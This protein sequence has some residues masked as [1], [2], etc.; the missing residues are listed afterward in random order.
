MFVKA[1][2]P[3]LQ[4][5]IQRLFTRVQAG[6]VALSDARSLARQ[7]VQAIGDNATDMVIQTARTQD[8]GHGRVELRE[9]QVLPIPSWTPWLQWPGAA[10]VFRLHRQTRSKKS[11]KLRTE[12]VFGITSLSQDK[13]TPDQLLKLCRG[14]WGIENRSHWVRD[15]TFDEDR[16]TV[17][18]RSLPQVMAALRN[19]V[20][21]LM[22]LAGK[23]N[24]AAACRTYAAN[25][26]NVVPLI[27]GVP[28]FE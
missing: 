14:H 13:A 27:Q 6:V 16:S 17:R 12:T 28:T 24:L 11:G 25:A 9:I 2:Q 5:N 7:R 10:Q 18:C 15:V 1:N 4:Q 20:I 23:Q 8:T 21:G 22:R 26:Q 3:V 19:T